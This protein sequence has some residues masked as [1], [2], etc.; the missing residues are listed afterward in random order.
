MESLNCLFEN[1]LAYAICDM[2]FRNAEK[3]AEEYNISHVCKSNEELLAMDE[4]E[5]VVVLTNPSSLCAVRLSMWK[6]P[7]IWQAS[8][9]WRM[10]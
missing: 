8:F 10:G 5:I 6:F 9:I 3:R 2:D 7:L 4:V 1:T